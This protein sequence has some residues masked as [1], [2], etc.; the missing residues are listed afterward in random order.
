MIDNNKLLDKEILDKI[1]N[2]LIIICMI[3]FAIGLIIYMIKS[4]IIEELI[5]YPYTAILYLLFIITASM[6]FGMFISSFL[7]AT[8]LSPVTLTKIHNFIFRG[9]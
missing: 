8:I 4:G 3:S 2:R 5:M 7:M 9:R 6:F 1:E